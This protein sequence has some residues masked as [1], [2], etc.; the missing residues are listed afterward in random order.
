MYVR[1]QLWAG[2]FVW[3]FFPV[4]GK[5]Q[6]RSVAACGDPLYRSLI[7]SPE[8]SKWCIERPFGH[9]AMW[10][11]LQRAVRRMLW[12]MLL[13]QLREEN[14]E[15]EIWSDMLR[16]ERS[17]SLSTSHCLSTY[18]SQAW[19]MLSAFCIVRLPS[20]EHVLSLMLQPLYAQLLMT[21]QFYCRIF[22]SNY[23]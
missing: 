16:I 3:D 17:L 21:F 14:C 13:M 23:M 15:V 22:Q 20:L 18:L 9:S 5:I 10:E 4:D 6:L 2:N 7:L 8:M 11:H 19:V 1:H 12:L